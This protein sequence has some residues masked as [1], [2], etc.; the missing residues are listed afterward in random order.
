MPDAA[1]GAGLSPGQAS[2]RV[3][4]VKKEQEPKEQEPVM[5]RW[6]RMKKG[7]EYV[8]L[9]Q[10]K[11]N[12][13]C[14]V[15]GIYAP[16]Q[17]V[18]RLTYYGLYALQHRGQES[19]GIA[20]MQGRQ[21][22]IH[23]GMGLVS[24]VFSDQ[25]ISALDGGEAAIGHVRYSTTGS[26]SLINAQPLVVHYQ[27]GMLALAHN[28]N[29]TNAA[30]LREELGR[31]G[32][33]FQTTID[34]EIII[35]LVT[36]HRRGGLEDALVKTMI[37]L[38]G[39]Y[40]VVM[41]AEGKLL[42]MRDQHGV[43]PLC[44]GRMGEGYCLAS[45]SSALDTIGAEFIRDVNPREI[46]LIDETG[47]HSRQVYPTPVPAGCAFEYI[48]FARPDST[49]D[50]INVLESRRR[51]GIEL[52]KEYPLEADV[53]IAVP[54]SGTAAALGYAQESGIPFDEGLVKNRYVGRTFIRP[55]QELREAA[56]RIKLNANAHILRDKRVVMVDDSIVRGTTS[57]RLIEMV[58]AA[59]AKEVHLLVSSPP[60]IHPCYYGIDTSEREQL[61]AARMDL[62]GIRRY[63]GAD[64]LYYLSEAGLKQA[65]RRLPVCLACFKGDYP[66]E[67]TEPKS[68]KYNFE[69]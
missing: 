42:G 41:L 24:E 20:A 18:A 23:K 4:T 51:M 68:G 26:S 21:I 53:V 31:D 52:A 27:N 12:E 35:N 34:S 13:E 62:E 22:K 10:D 3:T 17:E 43:R 38:R 25:V 7:E 15:F 55:T 57:S 58:R 65:L 5:S 47:L 48:Y 50:G 28:G 69:R 66:I 61:I 37:D 59:G 36:R 29:L 63:V 11:L 8:E 56:V 30:Q 54:D 67:I 14:G 39:A 1:A 40:A 6:I 19:T 60:V 9:R 32:A 46:I 45:E 44:I 2:P 49:L 33:V 16:G 64:S